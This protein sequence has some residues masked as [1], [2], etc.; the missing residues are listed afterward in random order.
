MIHCGLNEA[1]GLTIEDSAQYLSDRP[2]ILGRLSKEELLEIL[3]DGSVDA[4]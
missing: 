2:G 4:Q 3:D 1:H